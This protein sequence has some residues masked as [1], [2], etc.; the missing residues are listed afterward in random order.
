MQTSR[1]CPWT[2]I[3]CDIPA[4]GDGKWRSRSPEHVL[5]EMQ[6]LQD[7]LGQVEFPG[8]QT[9]GSLELRQD[10]DQQRHR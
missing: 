4:L 2:C 1:G 6:Q 8:Q 3:F 7:Q 9:T 10:F 5:G